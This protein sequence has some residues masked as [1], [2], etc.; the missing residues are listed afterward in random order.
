M[1]PSERCIRNRKHD[2]E[3]APNISIFRKILAW[4]R[5]ALRMI[6]NDVVDT[7]VMSDFPEH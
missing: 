7:G 2:K 4:N 5:S 1:T 3:L 6:E